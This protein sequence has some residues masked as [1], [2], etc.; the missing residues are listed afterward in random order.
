MVQNLGMT[1]PR[2][3][4][5]ISVLGVLVISGCTTAQI[6]DPDSAPDRVAATSSTTVA[7]AGATTT[8]AAATTT[9]STT[10][11][12]T[13]VGDTN[14]LAAGSGCTPSDVEL[15]DGTWFGF[16]AGTTFDQLEFDL[17]CWFTGDG[18]IAAATED[19]EESPPPNDYYIRNVNPTIRLLAVGTA[20]VAWLPNVGDATS[21]ETV[22]FGEW[23]V[24]RRTRPD[25]LQPGVWVTISEG[26]VTHVEEQYVP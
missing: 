7:D 20:D 12:A 26:V 17:A 22:E 13:T 1:N 11:V 18:A 6:D 24:Y 21:L 8:S 25:A 16:V 23:V 9:T 14:S 4:L 3:A 15:P 10:S 2:R 19:G 5:L